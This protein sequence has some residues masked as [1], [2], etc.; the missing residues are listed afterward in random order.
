[1][2][3]NS[4]AQEV[5]KR[6]IR[7]LLLS[8]VLF[9]LVDP[10]L[11]PVTARGQTL[12]AFSATGSL[13]TARGSHT[14]TLLSNGTVLIAGGSNFEPFPARG[15]ILASA[16]LYGPSSGAFSATGSL[17]APR[18]GHTATLLPNGS[19]LLAGGSGSVFWLASAELYDPTAGAFGSTG[20][21]SIGRIQHTATLLPNGKV[22]VAGGTSPSG[23]LAS[24]EL[25]DAATGTFSPTTGL[26]GAARRLHTATLLPNGKVLLTGGFRGNGAFEGVLASAE[27]YDP[28]TGAFSAT[29]SM[30]SARFLHTATLLPTG[31]V[32][33]AGGRDDGF[34]ILDSAE[35]YDPATGTFSSIRLFAP[36]LRTARFAHTAT[37]LPNGLVLI[38]GGCCSPSSGFLASAELYNWAARSF[39]ATGSMS[40]P[41]TDHTATLLPNDKVLVAGGHLDDFHVL[42]SAELYDT[43]CTLSVTLTPNVLWPPNHQLTPIT[44]DVQLTGTCENTV[45]TLASIFSNESDNG[46]GDGDMPNDI[47]GAIFGADD[48][49]FLLRAERSA[50]GTGRIYTVIYQVRDTSS[51]LTA[52]E[53]AEVRVPLNQGRP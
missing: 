32:L 14:A 33:V 6:S 35:L 39:S 19:V 40:S 43:Y 11:H 46:L 52:T 15:G 23:I 45:V 29:G 21:M 9:C 1:M 22:L 4:K 44:A 18:S 16:E 8:S 30:I 25:Y 2:K 51:G 53:S 31:K 42:A 41:R 37:L 27:L 28:A 36:D 5:L 48:R 7:S 50:T 34:R 3:Q 13:G 26:L 47:Q 17:G 10:I 38:A 12:G 20:S 49:S 24:A